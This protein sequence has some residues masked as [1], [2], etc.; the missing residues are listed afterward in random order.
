MRPLVIPSLRPASSQPRISRKPQ[1][2]GQTALFIQ[3]TTGGVE[4]FAYS[5]STANFVQGDSVQVVG[6]V[7]QYH[8]LT[9][10]E[11][12]AMDSL[13]FGLIKHNAII[14]K[15]KRITLHQYAVN[16][17]AY[18]G[19][20]IEIDTLYKSTGSWPPS[21]SGAS[22]E[23]INM[24]HKDSAQMYVNGQTDV[25][26]SIEPQYPINLVAVGSQYSSATTA[27]SGGWEII[28]RDSTDIKHTKFATFV[29]ISEARRDSSNLIAV[30][31]VIKDTLMIVGV[32]TSPNFASTY[33]EY[34][35]Q[36]STAGIEIYASGL[37]QTLVVGD[38][39]SVVGTVAQYRGLTEFTPLVLDTT[40]LV[41]LKHKAVV[42]KPK[43]LTLSQYVT[44]AENYEGLLI[45]ID[46]LY[47]ASGT[48]PG[49]ASGASISLMDRSHVDTV[50]MYINATTDI[51][52]SAEPIYPINLVCI[53]S[54]YSSGATVTT[55]GY[56][57]L[58]RDTT[59]FVHIVVMSVASAYSGIPT[60]FTLENNYPNPFN[61]STT[62]MYGIASQSHVTVKIY[63][64]LGQ[65]IATLVN[66]VQG[67]SYY[68]VVWN[69]TSSKG[70]MVSSGVYFYRITAA[71]VDGKSQPFSQVKKMLLMK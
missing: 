43:V 57:I 63:S 39:V 42:P 62:I 5:I 21:G 44:N 50:Q 59:D 13:H 54:Q 23:V 48:W 3:D 65:E 6:T 67:P 47:K 55:G 68:S 45:Q 66:D 9:E 37:G 29:K 61:P 4:V 22:I 33:T 17:E 35:V 18:E 7:S 32:I 15:P 56:E 71:P 2:S 8:G 26:G 1:G 16:S 64:V 41:F 12:I 19:L 49:S 40:H 52:G 36:D 11:P 27:D 28:P 70:N 30:H 10:F 25:P 51:G 31:S 34:F 20:L 69:G 24:T 58:P 46:T 38:S 60:T 53:G 14:P